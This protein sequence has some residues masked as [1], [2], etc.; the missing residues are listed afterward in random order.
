[1]AGIQK[2]VIKLIK[3]LILLMMLIS[4]NYPKHPEHFADIYAHG[5]F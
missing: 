5:L 3:Y 1:M 2:Y 4:V